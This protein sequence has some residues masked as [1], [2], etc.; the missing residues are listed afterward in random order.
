MNLIPIVL[1]LIIS[2]QVYAK[3]LVMPPIG[4][5][6]QCNQGYDNAGQPK[7]LNNLYPSLAQVCYYSGG[8]HLTY[9]IIENNSAINLTCI[10]HQPNN[11]IFSCSFS[12][13]NEEI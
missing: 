13:S 9:K 6:P 11:R 3:K 4:Q 7:I 10:G 12:A 1:L 8:A 2:I 5:S